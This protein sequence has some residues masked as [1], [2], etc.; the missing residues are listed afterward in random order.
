MVTLAVMRRPKI[1]KMSMSQ[2]GSMRRK[3]KLSSIA[4]SVPKNTNIRKKSASNRFSRV[5]PAPHVVHKRHDDNDENCADQ[6][7]KAHGK[8][9]VEV[10][11][12]A[13]HDATHIPIE[14]IRMGCFL[15]AIS[16]PETFI[17]K[18]D[19]RAAVQRLD[20]KSPD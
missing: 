15:D 3:K 9:D 19:P 18:A 14:V 11:I 10:A 6:T 16:A 4:L 5:G 17:A 12:V 8:R 2:T 13:M 7:D 1:A 20:G